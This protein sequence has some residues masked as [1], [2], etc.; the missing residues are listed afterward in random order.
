MKNKAMNRYLKKDFLYDELL[1]GFVSFSPDGQILSIN[2]T[3]ASWVGINFQEVQVLNFKSLMTKSSMLYYNMVVDPLLN[4][5]SVV[6]EISLKFSGSDG[7]FDALLNAES[8]KNEQGKLILI[9]ATVQK[10]TDRKRYENE[11]LREKRHAEEE[12]RKYEFLFNSAP[13][14]IWTTDAEGKILTVNER[15]KDYFGITEV[16]DVY[17][18]S[19]IFR[20][21][22]QKYQT[23][24]RHSLANGTAFQGEIRLQ[25]IANIPEW[26]MI[27]AEPYS[28]KDGKIEMWFFSST[29]INKQKMLQI[30]SQTEQKISLSNAYKT[31][32]DNQERFVSIAM[33]QSHMIR[34]PLANILGLVQLLSDEDA[35]PEF[36]NLLNMLLVSVEELDTMI[37]QANKTNIPDLNA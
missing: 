20:E 31:L 36:K 23:L 1:C 18:L 24:W 4:L 7:S 27:T 16:T 6:S 37:K 28:D 11:L 26:F 19:G 32:A 33:N 3:M 35:S 13:N 2:K 17:G 10:I 9:N 8:Y 5:K 34:K 15:V 21:D 30:A 22:R 25:G 14:Q 29:N 12:K